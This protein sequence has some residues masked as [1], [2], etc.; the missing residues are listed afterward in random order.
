MTP[1]LDR[2]NAY[3]CNS[4]VVRESVIHPTQDLLQLLHIDLNIPHYL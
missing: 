4:I 1:F 3:N 2:N